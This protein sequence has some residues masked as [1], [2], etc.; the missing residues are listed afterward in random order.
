VLDVQD[1]VRLA[2][3]VAVLVL[4]DGCGHVRSF[5]AW[6]MARKYVSGVRHTRETVTPL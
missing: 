3:R 2:R 4:R 5:G 1:D 6:A